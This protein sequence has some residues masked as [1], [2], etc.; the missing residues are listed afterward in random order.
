MP[1]STICS[2]KS[3]SSGRSRPRNSRGIA[4]ARAFG[5][6]A[7]R[8]I[9]RAMRT[10]VVVLMS[11]GLLSLGACRKSTTT[12]A[13]EEPSSDEA[14][15]DDTTEEDVVG[16]SQVDKQLPQELVAELRLAGDGADG[17]LLTLA[18]GFIAT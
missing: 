1:P 14:P 4:D 17:R 6:P 16:S 11:A 7:I 8:D 12:T 13:T 10:A 3:M 5:R 18:P 15:A 2:C 9:A